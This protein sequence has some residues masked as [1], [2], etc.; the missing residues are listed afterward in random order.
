MSVAL[1]DLLAAPNLPS[2]V[3]AARTRLKEEAERRTRF[4][5]EID[6]D[7]NAEFINGEVVMHSPARERHIGTVGLLVRLI[8]LHVD[9]RGLG[10]VRS[11]KALVRF[12]RNDYEPDVAFWQAERAAAFP[13]D[14][15]V[16]PVADF[17][18]EILAP[19]TASFDRGVKFQDY[20]AHGVGEYWI[21]DADERTIECYRRATPDGSFILENDP[22]G[23]WIESGVIAGLRFPR[24]AAFEATENVRAV[25]TLLREA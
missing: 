1:S 13:P 23:E 16:Y 3:E 24:L 22:R 18:A 17:I 14:Q 5:D 12:P 21:V 19:S 7:S 6:E 8:A 20:E 10:A 9:L 25:A 11:E 2:L 15:L 4:L